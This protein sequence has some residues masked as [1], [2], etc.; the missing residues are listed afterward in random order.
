MKPTERIALLTRQQT[1]LEELMEDRVKRYKELDNFIPDCIVSRIVEE[2]I[3]ITEK[4]EE[5]E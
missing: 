4:L 2:Y 1:L 5:T 3:E